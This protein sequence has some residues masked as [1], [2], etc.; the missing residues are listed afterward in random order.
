MPKKISKKTK[1][2]KKVSMKQ[3]QRQSVNVKI[4][5]DNSKKTRPRKS[6]SGGGS[7]GSANINTPVLPTFNTFPPPIPY[8]TQELR[9][10]SDGLTSGFSSMKDLITKTKEQ[11]PTPIHTSIPP[12]LETVLKGSET[13]FKTPKKLSD[14]PVYFRKPKKLISSDDEIPEPVIRRRPAVVR[15]TNPLTGKKVNVGGKTYN[16]L[17]DK[18]IL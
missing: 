18:G 17:K 9:S 1:K 3:K 10:I 7:G 14:E 2:T 4:N 13:G 5:I 15:V 11:P 16:E 8:D 12:P 6:T